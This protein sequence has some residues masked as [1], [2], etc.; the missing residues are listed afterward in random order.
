MASSKNEQRQAREARERLRRFTAR[1]SVHQHQQ[2]RRRRDNL[3]ALAGVLVV[4]ALATATQVFF[5]TAGPGAT[6]TPAPSPT[7]SSD[8]QGNVGAI[9]AASTAENR[10][11]TGSLTLNDVKL[12]ITLD[13][14]KA[15]QAVATFVQEVRD[16]YFTGKTCHRLTDG[17]SSLIQCGSADG[18]GK[19]DAD[20]SFGPIENAPE[21]GKYPA[22]TIAM[23]RAGDNAYSQG[24]QFFVMYADG[25]LPADSAGGYTVFGHVTSGLDKFVSEIASGG[26]V[27]GGPGGDHDGAPAIPTTITA[28]SIE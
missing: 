15:P 24:H 12:G 9:P 27:P 19:S 22:G 20:F 14:T 18:T 17:G 2:R 26:V 4:V 3:L 25:T 28:V 6:T 21:D 7:P 5:F 8:A 13:G 11:W 1:Q 16:G 23:A 10:Q